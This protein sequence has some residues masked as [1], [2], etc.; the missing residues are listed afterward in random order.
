LRLAV[1]PGHVDDV[2]AQGARKAR[3]IALPTM[4]SVKDILGLV[5]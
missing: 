5:R 1:D 2:L 4:N 3:E